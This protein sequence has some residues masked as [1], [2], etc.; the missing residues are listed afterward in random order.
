L[1]IHDFEIAFNADIA[2]VIDGD[3]CRGHGISGPQAAAQ[4]KS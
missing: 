1:L 3:F 2:V 4:R